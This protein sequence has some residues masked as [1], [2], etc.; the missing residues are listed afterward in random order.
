ME[1]GAGKGIVGFVEMSD[2]SFLQ[3]EAVWKE[4]SKFRH[5]WE[6]REDEL[7]RK[8]REAMGAPT[9]ELPQTPQISSKEE[10]IEWARN[11]LI[12]K[13]IPQEIARLP[14]VPFEG[15]IEFEG[16]VAPQFRE[17]LSKMEV[18]VADEYSEALIYRLFGIDPKQ[19]FF[20]KD[21]QSKGFERKKFMRAYK[22]L[23]R[24]FDNENWRILVNWKYPCEPQ[25]E[26][27]GMCGLEKMQGDKPLKALGLVGESSTP[28]EIKRARDLYRQ[29][30]NRLGLRSPLRATKNVPKE[31][32][33]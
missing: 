23:G 29:R 18:P 17:K 21:A 2:E 6:G 10:A 15:K 8:I 24:L 4:A 12:E 25:M 19:A 32:K 3:T 20:K 26:S 30:L 11:Y 7:F 14:K 1:T 27:E 28:A 5:I 9:K 22:G 13:L 31:Q 33:M 16:D